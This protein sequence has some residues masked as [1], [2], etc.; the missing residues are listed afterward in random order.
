MAVTA[1]IT[2]AKSFAANK[3]IAHKVGEKLIQTADAGEQTIRIKLMGKLF[4]STLCNVKFKAVL[5]DLTVCN[6]PVA[7]M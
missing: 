3:S 6:M 2:I 7:W 4:Q 5:S 1:V